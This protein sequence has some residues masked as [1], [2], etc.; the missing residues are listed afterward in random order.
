MTKAQKTKA[1][2]YYPVVLN[3]KRQ[4]CKP[5]RLFFNVTAATLWYQLPNENTGKDLK[6]TGQLISTA[7]KSGVTDRLELH[8]AARKHLCVVNKPTM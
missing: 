5:F 7:E 6:K 3:T 4:P 2:K 8:I 1:H